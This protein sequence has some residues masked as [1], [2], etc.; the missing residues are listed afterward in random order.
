MGNGICESRLRFDSWAF[1]GKLRRFD[2]SL[3]RRSR[4]FL[5]PFSQV[6]VL[7]KASEE[8]TTGVETLFSDFLDFST[9]NSN[10]Q[11]PSPSPAPS[12]SS[13]TNELRSPSLRVIEPAPFPSS[14]NFQTQPLRI[15]DHRAFGR[16]RQSTRF[17][18]QFFIGVL[19][20]GFDSSSPALRGIWRSILESASLV[21]FLFFR[22]S[23]QLLSTPHHLR[24]PGYHPT[25]SK[26]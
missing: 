24:I 11:P 9:S 7:L 20:P 2:G 14:S 4:D 13:F 6:G 22:P 19:Q 16:F 17:G 23:P 10:Y 8:G 21:F 15:A 5:S 18:L 1:G 12:P 26:Q 25:S 3:H